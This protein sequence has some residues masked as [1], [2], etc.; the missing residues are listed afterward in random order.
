MAKHLAPGASI[1]D[2]GCGSGRDL[3]WFKKRG[4]QLT[5]FDRSPG[6][7]KLARENADCK[8]I[9][10]D[11]RKFDFSKFS[12]DA[13]ILVGALVHISYKEFQIVFKGILKA[14]KKN[15]LILISLNEGRGSK[16]D[17]TGRTFWLWHDSELRDIF[18]HLG[19]KVLEFNRQETKVGT[20]KIWL[21]YVLERN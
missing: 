10:D 6:L 16:T 17:K 4:Y 9:E 5:G 11:F 14:L 1:L 20:G 7:S 3:L 18:K 15:G 21:G 13:I 8:V 12:Y 2:V 19:L